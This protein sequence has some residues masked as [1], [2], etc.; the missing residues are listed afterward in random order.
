M[1]VEHSTPNIEPRMKRKA[2][3][4]SSLHWER[5]ENLERRETT[6]RKT[7]RTKTKDER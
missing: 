3:D 7:M 4:V 5:E 1:N 2:K 6:R